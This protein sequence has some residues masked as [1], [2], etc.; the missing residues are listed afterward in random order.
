MEI[1]LEVND[2][3]ALSLANAIINYEIYNEDT[4][5]ALE[6]IRQIGKALLNYVDSMDRIDEKVNTQNEQ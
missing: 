5:F 6:E 2:Y 1:I 4:I 3:S